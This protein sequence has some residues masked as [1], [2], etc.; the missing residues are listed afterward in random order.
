[1]TDKSHVKR[2]DIAG[3]AADRDA[4][5]RRSLPWPAPQRRWRRGLLLTLALVGMVLASSV[6]HLTGG[7]SA[8]AREAGE[9]AE[10]GAAIL[11]PIAGPLGAL[12][13]VGLITRVRRWTLGPAWFLALPPTA[14]LLQELVERAMGAGGLPGVGS[15]PSLVATVFLQLP[16]AVVA[17]VLARALRGAIRR[18]SRF[19]RAAGAPARLRAPLR[20]WLVVPRPPAIPTTLAGA[21]F[22]RAPPTA[23]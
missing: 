7:G 4:V 20:I 22:G 11:P 8:E 1:M 6:T 3:R 21:H 16:F 10:H 13:L 12:L 18:V 17:F 19:L 2:L 9:A 23:A 14:F 5:V 15:E